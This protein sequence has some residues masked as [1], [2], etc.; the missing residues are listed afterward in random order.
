MS[1]HFS[2]KT[3]TITTNRTVRVAQPAQVARFSQR[4]A[5][6]NRATSAGCAALTEAYVP[7]KGFLSQKCPDIRENT[8]IGE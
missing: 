8:H 7:L 2:R 5:G 4:A 6:E 1:G 3:S